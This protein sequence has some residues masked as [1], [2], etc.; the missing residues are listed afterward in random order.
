MEWAGFRLAIDAL[1]ERQPGPFSGLP[2]ETIAQIR[3]GVS[4]PLGELDALLFTHAHGD[5]F[6]AGLTEQFLSQTPIGQLWIPR[7]GL[8]QSKGLA[9]IVQHSARQLFVLDAASHPSPQ[10]A[11]LVSQSQAAGGTGTSSS[12]QVSVSIEAFR[13]IHAGKAYAD[14]E[15]YGFLMTIGGRRMLFAGDGTAEP[16]AYEHI[17]AGRS[18]D[19]AVLNP[20]FVHLL[21]G[22]RLIQTVLQPNKILIN[23]IPFAEEDPEGLREQVRCDLERYQDRLPPALV[24]QDPWQQ[25]MV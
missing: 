5:H 6:S 13:L 20:L 15:H 17:L 12:E 18:L 23:H 24:L 7:A 2:P 4:N 10:R 8:Q 16:E 22:R 1:H 14:V 11:L 21:A 3:Q 19:L 25:V 9:S